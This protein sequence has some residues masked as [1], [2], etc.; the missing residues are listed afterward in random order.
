MPAS[1]DP[2]TISWQEAVK[3]LAEIDNRE[4]AKSLLDAVIS[5]AV[6]YYPRR[7]LSLETDYQRGLFDLNTG[8]WR[9][10]PRDDRPQFIRVIRADFE[11]HFQLSDLSSRFVTAGV[12]ANAGKKGKRPRRKRD[13]AR[14]A[15]DNLFPNA[16]PEQGRLSNDQLCKEVIGWIEADQ[17]KKGLAKTSISDDT[18]LRAA[19]RMK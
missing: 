9:N 6:G 2:E 11:S 13:L 14:E 1:S 12:L 18:I 10:R 7:A 17:K 16:I 15:L 8:A 5:N 4:P 19:G 3:R